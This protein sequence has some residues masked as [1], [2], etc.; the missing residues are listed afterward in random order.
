M[1]V[2]GRPRRKTLTPPLSRSPRCVSPPPSLF[3]ESRAFIYQ[4]IRRFTS[5]HTHTVTHGIHTTL[6]RALHGE[7]R[8]AFSP[9]SE[10]LAARL[11]SE[12]SAWRLAAETYNAGASF[13][14]RVVVIIT[15]ITIII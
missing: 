15:I 1:D 9:E 12:L 10:F 7:M 3:D 6:Q 5:A 2:P 8:D 13:L 4:L 11:T 14:S